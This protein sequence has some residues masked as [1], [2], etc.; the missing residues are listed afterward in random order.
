MFGSRESNTLFT[1]APSLHTRI[2]RFGRART[3]AA[4]SA[5]MAHASQ[6]Y[7]T[8]GKIGTHLANLPHALKICNTFCQ[9]ATR[10]EY[11]QYARKYC[12][13]GGRRGDPVPTGGDPVPTRGDPVPTLGDP[14]LTTWIHLF[15]PPWQ[16]TVLA[17]SNAF[18]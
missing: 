10:L 12:I 14:V 2:P 3:V 7:R 13:T 4:R 6:I 8:F 17:D 1:A 15:H 18:C 16:T 5:N 11:L 9:F